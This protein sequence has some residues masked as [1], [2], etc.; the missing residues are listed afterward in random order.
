M[1]SI[2]NEHEIELMREAN[3]IVCEIL[4]QL[5]SMI[6]SGISTYSL[7]KK[8]GEIIFANDA[9]AVFNGFTMNGMEPFPYNICAS[10][11]NEIVHGYSSKKKKLREGD[12]IGIDVG[13]RKNGFCGDGAR[14]FA[15]GEISKENERLMTVTNLALQK[16]IEKCAVGNRIGDISAVIEKAA[17]ENGFFVADELTGH[18]VGHE[19]HEAPIVYN[20]G[21]ENTGPR[22]Q[23]GMTIAIEPMFNIGTS[24]ITGNEWVVLTEDGSCS[25]HF[26]DTILITKDK[27][28]VLTQFLTPKMEKE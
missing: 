2:K 22:L 16:A 12:I 10:I 21:K 3:R 25:A 17:V 11:N 19:L 4:D 23:Q 13:V 7:N 26:E 8:A 28:E 6:E 20:S 5:G 24:R 14:T 9:E 27:A 1:I 18:G 15:V